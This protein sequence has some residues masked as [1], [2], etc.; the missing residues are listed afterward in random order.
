MVK[1]E[2]VTHGFKISA[3]YTLVRPH[4]NDYTIVPDEEL[5]RKTPPGAMI[6][7]NGSDIIAE[8]EMLLEFHI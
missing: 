6:P 3:R 5:F 7:Q 4:E 2:M 8:E 1:F